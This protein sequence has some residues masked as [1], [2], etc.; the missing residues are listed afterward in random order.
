MEILIIAVG[1]YL[2]TNVILMTTATGISIN[3]LFD[4]EIDHLKEKCN[5]KIQ[6]LKEK[7]NQDENKN[8]DQEFK[9]AEKNNDSI[10]DITE[11]K[12]MMVA[13]G[14]KV[15]FHYVN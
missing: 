12:D 14:V 4:K 5:E 10:S 3:K 6:L 15:K 13:S 8:E 2:A 9:V 11:E 7:L 1:S